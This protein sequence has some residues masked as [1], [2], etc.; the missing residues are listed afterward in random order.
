M[1]IEFLECFLT[2][3]EQFSGDLI[4]SLIQCKPDVADYVEVSVIK[5]F[6]PK[7]LL[8]TLTPKLSVYIRPM[9]VGKLWIFKQL[10]F[11]IYCLTTFKF[12]KILESW[13]TQAE[14][15]PNFTA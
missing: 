2:V 1:M 13:L 12:C 14:K 3:G 9:K 7:I 4:N 11:S 10:K 6:T 15:V 5:L 8:C